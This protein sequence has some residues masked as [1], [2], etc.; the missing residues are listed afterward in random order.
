[1]LGD[2]RLVSREGLCRPIVRNIGD[3]NA[4]PKYQV[5]RWM[6][7]LSRVRHGEQ[8]PTKTRRLSSPSELPRASCRPSSTLTSYLLIP[9]EPVRQYRTILLA[10]RHPAG[11]AL[12]NT[13]W[14]PATRRVLKKGLYALPMA[15]C[16]PAA[17]LR[18]R[19]SIERQYGSF[20]PRG[21]RTTQPYMT[22]LYS[23]LPFGGRQSQNH[24]K[25]PPFLRRLRP[26]EA[27][28]LSLHSH[29]CGIIRPGRGKARQRP[30]G[31]ELGVSP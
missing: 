11:N 1:M 27:A 8:Q 21:I 3:A 25:F 18:P 12:N 16:R 28:P 23:T 15:L 14:R 17:Y 22:T 31:A 29:A 7:Q 2:Q 5:P 19:Q 20:R 24:D 30:A 10:S 26:K 9:Y 13:Y 4:S 6:G